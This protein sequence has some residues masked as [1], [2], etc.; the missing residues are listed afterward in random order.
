MIGLLLHPKIFKRSCESCRQWLYDDGPDGKQTIVERIKGHPE[1]RG[2]FCPVPC[3]TDVGCPKGHYTKPNSMTRQNQMAYDF[4]KMHK[5]AGIPLPD[6]PIVLRNAWLI[7]EAEAE[8]R[9]LQRQELVA[10]VQ[11]G[12][13]SRRVV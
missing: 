1:R 11:L 9:E 8:C 10:A 2:K 12:A 5:A 6:D 4:H 3:D 7:E 13:V